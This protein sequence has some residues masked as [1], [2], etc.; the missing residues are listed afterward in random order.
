MLAQGTF[1]TSTSQATPYDSLEGVVFSRSRWQRRFTGDLAGE[2]Q[3]EMLG[4]RTPTPGSAGYVALERITCELH[5]KRG[6]FALLHT[7]LMGHG[8]RTLVIQIVPDSGTGALRSIRGSMEVSVEGGAR[9]YRLHY[10]L[11]PA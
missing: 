5:G 6:S 10:E 2:G 11:R 7:A 8:P 3:L 1:E 9:S 4:A